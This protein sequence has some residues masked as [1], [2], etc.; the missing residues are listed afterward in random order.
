MTQTQ[1]AIFIWSVILVSFGQIC[2]L[3]RCLLLPRLRQVTHCPWCWRDAGIAQDFPAPWSSTI[4]PYHNR[5]IRA[6]VRARRQS[7]R[8]S[9]STGP[10]LADVGPVEEVLV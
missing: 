6:Q 8:L 4:C 2:L 3:A 9:A 7:L 5:Q 10:R 1:L